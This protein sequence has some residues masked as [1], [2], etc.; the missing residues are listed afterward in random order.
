M[1]RQKQ[2]RALLREQKATA[3]DKKPAP[4]D[5]FAKYDD[6]GNLSCLICKLVVPGDDW[7][8]H[9]ATQK[10]SMVRSGGSFFSFPEPPFLF[11]SSSSSPYAACPP[12]NFKTH[13][14]LSFTHVF[15]SFYSSNFH[16]F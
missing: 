7:A 9:I 12:V 8:A 3:K 2:L 5:K 10:H 11:F 14:F 15:C 13:F 16:R 4:N 1:D 6:E